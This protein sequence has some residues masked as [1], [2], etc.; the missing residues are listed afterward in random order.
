MNINIS[1]YLTGL[2]NM[3]SEW[4]SNMGPSYVDAICF[5]EKDYKKE[6]SKYYNVSIE[7][8]DFKETSFTFKDF[9]ANWFGN[10]DKLIDSLI[11]YIAQAL[12]DAIFVYELSNN[13]NLTNELTDTGFY[14]IEDLYL[15]MFK[16][17]VVL[18][19]LGNNE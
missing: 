4:S 7:S 3:A 13:S 18:F 19:I 5:K 1:N 16:E 10:N 2:T 8:I 9:L 11:Y 14:F 6:I 12:G 15:I 17:Y